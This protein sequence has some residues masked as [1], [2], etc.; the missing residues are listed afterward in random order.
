M[1]T[2]HKSICYLSTDLFGFVLNY[3]GTVRDVYPSAR[4]TPTE[5]CD[6]VLKSALL[7][8]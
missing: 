7:I 6:D 2:S 4:N 8:D 1:L 3:D 5:T